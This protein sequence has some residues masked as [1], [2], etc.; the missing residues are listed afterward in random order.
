MFQLHPQLSQ[1][2]AYLGR[3]TLC[4][5]LWMRDANYPWAIL[6]PDREEVREIH[7]LSA[8]DQAQL[9]RESSCLSRVLAARFEAHKMNLGALGNLVPQLHIHHVVRYRSD[10]AWP[11]PVWGRVPP[12]AYDSQV[13]A[14]TLAGLQQALQG[15]MGFQSGDGGSVEHQEDR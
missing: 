5:V 7:E 4:H 13:L 3:F 10:P 14:E 2:C 8:E 12:Q 1:D 6:V 11:A 9:I 15:E